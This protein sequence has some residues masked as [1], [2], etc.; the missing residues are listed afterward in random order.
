[1]EDAGEAFVVFGRAEGFLASFQLQNLLPGGG[2]DGSEG[3]V[4]QGAVAGD[5]TGTSVSGAGDVDGDDHAELIVGAPGVSDDAPGRAFVVFGADEFDAVLDLASLF[6]ANGGDGSAGVVL[7]GEGAAVAGPGSAGTSVAAAGDVDDDGFGDVLVGAPD[8][9]AD[10]HAGEGGAAYLLFG[11]ARDVDAD[12]VADGEDNCTRVA[13]PDQTDSNHEGFGNACDTD[14]DGDCVTNFIDLG[15]L[16]GEFFGD[17]PDSD[18]DGDGLVNFV[19]LGIMKSYFFFP[20]GPSGVASCTE[21]H[22]KRASTR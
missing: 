11:R 12:G 21:R 16:K 4:L 5:A 6:D 15:I 18:F 19:D 10:G 17:D 2:G 9:T 22:R 13:N 1:M 8:Q 7:Q 20:P 14:L 3:F